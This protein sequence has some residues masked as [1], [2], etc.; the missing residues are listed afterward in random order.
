M[1]T[2]YIFFTHWEKYSTKNFSCKHIFI[3]SQLIEA[4][5]WN[6]HSCLRCSRGVAVAGCNLLRPSPILRCGDVFYDII[7]H[8]DVYM[9]ESLTN[10]VMREAGS[11]NIHMVCNKL[12]NSYVGPYWV[13]ISQLDY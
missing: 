2:V 11:Q 8:I 3:L 10:Y 9:N 6:G 12:Q 7:L 4:V 13:E 5:K 1:E